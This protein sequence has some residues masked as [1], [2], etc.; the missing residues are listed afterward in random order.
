MTNNTR[1]IPLLVIKKSKQATQKVM[2]Y[3]VTKLNL[4]IKINESDKL[5]FASPK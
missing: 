4:K 5:K 1:R 2:L 3:T